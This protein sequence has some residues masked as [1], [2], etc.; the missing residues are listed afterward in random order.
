MNEIEKLRK[1]IEI[2]TQELKR[3]EDEKGFDPMG[4]WSFSTEADVEGRSIK[5]LG[6]YTGNIFDGIKLYAP[7]QYYTLSVRR[8]G[9]CNKDILNQKNKVAH[10]TIYDKYIKLHNEK[11]MMNKLEKFL[12]TNVT[13]NDSNYYAAIKLEW[14][15]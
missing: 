11:D 5:E 7:K 3:L 8:V 13:M 1:E 15:D 2:K 4:K 10:I 14:N 6:E 12:P 9:D